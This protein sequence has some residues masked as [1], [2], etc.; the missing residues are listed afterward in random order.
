MNVPPTITDQPQSLTAVAGSNVTFTVTATGTLP[1]SY[2][3]R[4]NGTNIHYTT[5][6]AYTCNNAQSKDAGSYSVVVSNIAGTLASADAVLTVSQP[7]PPRIDWIGLL[8]DGQIQLQV[9][10]IPGHYAVESTTNLAD[11]AELTN[12]T[13]ATNQFEYLDP[14]T[15]LSP[16]FY[17][18]RLL[19]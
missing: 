9:S 13:T 6:S 3:W 8:P 18:A 10:G 14:R 19:W 5:A 7:N 15:D 4:F 12:F 16:R 1:L 11:W 2:Q 17:R